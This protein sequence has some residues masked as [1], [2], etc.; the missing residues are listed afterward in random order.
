[1]SRLFVYGTLK[2]E[3]ERGTYNHTRVGL[4]QETFL[5]LAKVEGC[6]LV[7]LGAYPALFRAPVR[8]RTS[9]VEGE[10]WEIADPLRWRTIA[11]MEWGAGYHIEAVPTPYGEAMA[12]FRA[13]S[14]QEWMEAVPPGK[15]GVVR[16]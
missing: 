13:A 14:L 7:S 8:F 6:L 5:G 16:W 11:E 1:M 3:G 15:D 4:D 9:P 2:K 10:V 12:F